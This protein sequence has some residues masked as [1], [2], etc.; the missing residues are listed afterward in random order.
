MIRK[1]LLPAICLLGGS[2]LIAIG[3]WDHWNPNQINRWLA[4]EQVYSFYWYRLARTLVLVLLVAVLAWQLGLSKETPPKGLRRRAAWGFAVAVAIPFILLLKYQVTWLG[5]N[6]G[7]SVWSYSLILILSAVIS[8]LVWPALKNRRLLERLDHQ[9]P[10]IILVGMVVYMTVYGGLAIAR[11]TSFR[12]NALDL[13]T[14][15]QAMWNTSRG[16]LLEY[17]PL[18]MA[19]DNTAADLS[20][21]SRLVGGYLELIFLP[22][23]LLYWL[24]ADPRLLIAVQAIVLAS[25]AIPLYLLARS[26]LEDSV[27]SLT[28]T[29]AYLL[30]LPL[31]YVTLA[32]FHASALMIPFLLWAWQVAQQRRWRSYYLAIGIALL[33]RV[34]TALALL[35]VGACL[36]LQKASSSGGRQHLRHGAVTILI[37]L[38]W[39]ALDFGLVVPWAKSTY[40]LGSNH[41]GPGEYAGLVQ[42]VPGTA[43]WVLAQP[44]DALGALLGREELQILVDLIAPLGGTPLLALLALLPA[45][46][47]LVLNILTAAPTQH[48][49]PIHYLAP[50]IPFLFIAAVRGTFNAGRW[51]TRLTGGEQRQGLSQLEGSR[52]T[53]IF[54]LTMTLLAAL[55]LSS[56]PPGPKFRLTD[57][58]HIGERERELNN[59]LDLI[60]ANAS[61]SAQGN[62][63]PHLSRR[64]VIYRFPTVADAEYLVLDLDYSASKTPLDESAFYAT[65]EGLL[66]DPSF[67]VA[68]FEN[69]VLLLQRGP[70]QPPPAFQENLADYREG[71][72]RSALVEYRGS[73]RLRVDSL[74]QTV[75]A[76]ENRGTQSWETVGPDPIQLSYHW[77]TADGDLVEWDG[78][79]T[80]LGQVVK[81]NDALDQRAR[82]ATPAEPGDYVLEWDLMH[83]NRVWFGERGGI[84]LR[85]E[86][87]VME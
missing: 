86:V 30:Y 19:F 15:D 77:W 2:I 10:L 58:Y 17:T 6:Y 31:H 82:F 14:M 40:G 59:T 43:R 71:L 32:D 25:G 80:P 70:G 26:Q 34:D 84:T 87:S 85:V 4:G 24:W 3:W 79:S 67:H 57:Y 83:K 51:I 21:N 52:L 76:L 29:L 44:L 9:G 75:V 16:R 11:H 62:L 33:C 60:S 41:L 13:G 69:G 66:V 37:G 61:V 48:A 12:S 42:D 63:F 22:L 7:S 38:A 20:P 46:P 1:S 18:S 73:R 27:A 8:W 54:A 23:S 53:A 72:Y 81:P 39:M 50:V 64:P 28:I 5:M 68:A 56:L 35:G 78:L 55:F 65:V 74:Y 47:V 49:I 45:L 36:I